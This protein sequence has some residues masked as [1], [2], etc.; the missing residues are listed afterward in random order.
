MNRERDKMTRRAPLLQIQTR[1][2]I[3]KI[4]SLF[5]IVKKLCTIAIFIFITSLSYIKH[6]YVI[7]SL[8]IIRFSS[9]IPD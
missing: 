3:L 7:N 9:D 4:R 8:N 1:K 6:V 5:V 2:I